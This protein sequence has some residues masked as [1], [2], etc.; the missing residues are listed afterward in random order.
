ML[1][2]PAEASVSTCVDRTYSS[3]V[4]QRA[5]VRD[6]EGIAKTRMPCRIAYNGLAIV[7]E[8]SGG[9]AIEVGQSINQA[10]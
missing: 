3:R 8:G 1:M 4:G 10:G 2:A 5:C 7:K 6:R 9:R